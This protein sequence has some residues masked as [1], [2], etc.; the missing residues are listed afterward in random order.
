MTTAGVKMTSFE[1]LRTAWRIEVAFTWL[2]GIRCDL[3]GN[4]SFSR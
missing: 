3:C 2:I 4:T 1:T